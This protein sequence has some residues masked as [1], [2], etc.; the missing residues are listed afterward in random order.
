[1]LLRKYVRVCARARV[2]REGEDEE[3]TGLLGYSRLLYFAT[4]VCVLYAWLR[5]FRGS[6]HAACTCHFY[7]VRRPTVSYRKSMATVTIRTSVLSAF[8]RRTVVLQFLLSLLQAR[9]RFEGE[10][11]EGGTREIFKLIAVVFIVGRT[12]ARDHSR[13][14]SERFAG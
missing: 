6:L 3:S 12:R 8:R 4:V 13:F 11:R 10:S 1:M 9:R 2:A 14:V 7:T 5:A